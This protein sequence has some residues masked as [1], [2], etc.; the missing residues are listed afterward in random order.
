[1]HIDQFKFI[2]CNIL[3][4]WLENN[5]S[6]ALDL[7]KK[8]EGVIYSFPRKIKIVVS[9]T[10]FI[11][12]LIGERKINAQ[13]QELEVD[14]LKKTSDTSAYINGGFPIKYP[15]PNKSAIIAEDKTI[16]DMA[17][18]RLCTEHDNYA[19]EKI[20]KIQNTN[21][22]ITRIGGV[23]QYPLFIKKDASNLLFSN[24]EILR[25]D[26]YRLFFRYISTM[27]V[28]GKNCEKDS[29]KG[30]LTKFLTHFKPVSNYFFGFNMY[31]D[32]NDSTYLKQLKSIIYQDVTEPT[33]DKFLQDRSQDFA[34]ALNHVEAISQINLKIIEKE[35]WDKSSLKPDYLLKTEEGYYNILDLKKGLLKYKSLTKGG[36]SRLRFIDYV[37]E[38]IAQLQGYQRYFESEKNRNWAKENLDVEVINPIL[39]GVIGNHNNFDR[40]KID[41]VLKSF[42]NNII[43]LSY[44]ELVNLYKVNIGGTK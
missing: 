5:A 21:P 32:T 29:Y 25:V 26:S 41:V 12:E 9:P 37:N 39:Y 7:M 24:L 15:K 1:M 35:G 22:K 44:N 10:H 8:Q 34:K 20:L 11:A 43:I 42:K 6:V 36:Y 33:I 23:D 2:T 14:T 17:N 18:I 3:N 38:L 31:F 27:I 40:S 4:T 28:V 16:K 13:F 30:N 19:V